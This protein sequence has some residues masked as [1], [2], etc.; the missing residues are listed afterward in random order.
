MLN[1][2]VSTQ[3]KYPYLAHVDFDSRDDKQNRGDPGGNGA[4]YDRFD[5]CPS[6]ILRDPF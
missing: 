1:E 5:L 6:P 4:S 2:I 3:R